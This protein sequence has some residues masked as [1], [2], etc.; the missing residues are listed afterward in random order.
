MLGNFLIGLR[1]GLEASL[2]VSILV[3][4]LVR[5]GRRDRLPRVWVG[6]GL[7]VA[8]SLGFGALLSF[9]PQGL[10]FTAQELIGGTL[11]IV[12]VGLVTWMI[13]WMAGAAKTIAADLRH[14]VDAADG[15]Y[16][17]LPL[18]AAIAVGREGLETALFLWSATRVAVA[19]GGSAAGPLLGALLG[20]LVAVA[21][22]FALYAG[23]IRINLGRFFA[24]TGGFLVVVAAGV[25]AYGV[26]DLQEAG[27]LPGLNDLAFDVSAAVPPGSLAGTLLKGVFNFSPTPSVLEVVVWAGYLAVVGALFIRAVRR[28]SAAPRSREPVAASA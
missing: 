16:W 4:Y 25:L 24:V 12:A 15:I 10:S 23:A 9:G 8:V 28:N 6:V 5:T 14:Q 22:G 7:A 26:H 3:A 13:F 20:L 11:S 18:V 21:L 19:D 17:S 2:V 27:V 1:E